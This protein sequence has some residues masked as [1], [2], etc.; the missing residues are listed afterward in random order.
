MPNLAQIA[1]VEDRDEV[2]MTINDD[3]NQSDTGDLF[4]LCRDKNCSSC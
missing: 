1:V 2:P 3:E 4:L